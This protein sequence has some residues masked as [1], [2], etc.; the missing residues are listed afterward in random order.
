MVESVSKKPDDQAIGELVRL[1]RGSTAQSTIATAMKELGHRW[2]Q[3]TVWAVE[4][5]ERSLKLAEGRD[6]A[7][8]LGVSVLDLLED[9]AGSDAYVWIRRELAEADRAGDQLI[10]AIIE[11]TARRERLFGAGKWLEDPD[12][13]KQ[14]P[15]SKREA[16]NREV[17]DIANM[18]LKDIVDHVLM[19]DWDS[20]RVES[21]NSVDDSPID[22]ELID[23]IN[24]LRDDWRQLPDPENDAR[25]KR[26]MDEMLRDEES[27]DGVDPEAT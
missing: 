3:A 21:L 12:N 10:E 25:H 7:M 17:L 26:M 2:S 15:E 11:W 9:Q 22:L 13:L 6:L 4:K 16:V 14:I 1:A 20:G 24:L 27:R 18:T 23:D 19:N 8:V 5:G